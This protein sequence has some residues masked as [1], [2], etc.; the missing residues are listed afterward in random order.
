MSAPSPPRVVVTA[1]HAETRAVLAGLRKLHRIPT[2][3]FRAWE[4]ETSRGPIRVVQAGI[5]PERARLALASLPTPHGLVLCVGFAGG[6]TDGAPGDVV[7]P[8]HVVWSRGSTLDRYDVPT[9]IWEGAARALATG[10]SGRVLHGPLLSSSTVLASPRDKRAAHRKT[11]AVA[12]EMETAGLLSVAIERGV[13]VLP[14]RI[15]LD[16]ADVSLESLPP[17]L[18]GSWPA[19]IRL[20]GT[21][22]AWP[23]VWSLVRHIPTATA[24]LREALGIVLAAP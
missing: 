21:P 15:V 20:L 23:S 7:L 22:R 2:P 4:G 12:V 3:G 14:L 6:L 19:R 11:G 8:T 16:T 10:S 5:G 18:E 24:R 1:V 13:A 9:A 17:D